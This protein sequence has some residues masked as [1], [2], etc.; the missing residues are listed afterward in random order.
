MVASLVAQKILGK[1]KCIFVFKYEK[2]FV[3]NFDNLPSRKI[4]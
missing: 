1:I 4:I 3:E 2:P